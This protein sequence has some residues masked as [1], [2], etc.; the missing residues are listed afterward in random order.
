MCFDFLSFQF[1]ERKKILTCLFFSVILISSHFVLLK[2]WTAAIL[3]AIATIRYLI[4][5]FST[6]SKLKYFFCSVSVLAAIFTFCGFISIC[7]CLAAVFQT[8][9]T[10]NKND[11]ILR[12]LMIIG[13]SFWILHNYLIGSPAAVIMETSFLSSNLIGY[14]RF[15]YR[16]RITGHKYI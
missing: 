2:Q 10:F 4:S 16:N 12:Q 8:L 7:S 3:M 14:Y 1:K 11:K 13:T 9:A 15:Y 5:I 6:S